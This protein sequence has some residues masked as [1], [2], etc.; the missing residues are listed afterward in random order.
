MIAALL[1]MAARHDLGF[2]LTGKGGQALDDLGRALGKLEAYRA[3]RKKLSLAYSDAAIAAPEVE[4]WKGQLRV[5]GEKIWPLR[6]FARRGVALRRTEVQM[7][8]LQ[9]RMRTSYAVSWLH[10]IMM[11]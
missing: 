5:V 11:F 6:A 3:E 4:T 7:S 2:A 1:P 8:E 10:I 9:L